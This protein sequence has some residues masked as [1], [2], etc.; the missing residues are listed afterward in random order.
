MGVGLL[1]GALAAGVGAGTTIAAGVITLGFSFT[2]ALTSLAVGALSSLL[3]PK[4]KSADF[5][6]LA[7]GFSSRANGITQNI[8]QAIT[9]RRSIYGDVRV[10][11]SLVFIESTE[12]DKY[13]H[14]VLVICDHEVE[15][16]GEVWFD[17]VSIPPDYIDGDGNV[18][19]GDF[20]NR[21]RIKKYLGTDA[22]TA[23]AD[24]VAETSAASTFRGR[25]VSYMYVRLEFDRDVYPTDIPTITAFVKGKK[26]FDTRDDVTRWTPNTSLF[27]YDF[28]REDTDA[29][30]PGLGVLAANI[31]ETQM[32]A[33]ANTCDEMVT[34][35]DLDDTI[36]EADDTT[37]I[38]TLTGVNGRLQ[39]Q[40]G[41]Q[42][43]AIGGSLPTGLAEAT[44]YYVIPYQRKDTVRIKLATSLA[45][46]IAGT[47]VSITADGSGTIRK[48]AEPRYHGGSVQETGRDPDEILDDL[49]SGMGGSAVHVGDAWHILAAAYS[50]P[51][52]SFDENN[53]LSPLKIRTGVGRRDRF[54]LVKGVYA[55]PLNDG[56]PTDYP[57]VTNA[58]YVTNDNGRT[59]PI[60][61]DLPAT[62][63]P[64]TAQR[65]AKIKLEKHRQELF[66][67][68]DFDLD[69]FQVQPGDTINLSNTRMGWT[70]KVF[71]VV[72]WEFT[73]KTVNGAPLFYVKLILQET[74]SAAYDWNN[75]EETAVDPAPNTSLPNPLQ[76]GVVLGFSLDSISSQTQDGDAIYNVVAS[77]LPP[78]DQFVISGGQFEVE[79]KEADQVTYKSDGRVDGTVT[80]VQL[81]ALNPDTLYDIR[82]FAFNSL[83][84]RSP[85]TEIN[86][87]TVGQTVSSEVQ[88]WEAENLTTEDWENDTLATKDWES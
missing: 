48:I 19:T 68:A 64:H 1:V 32:I 49:L 9:V 80:E 40:I 65:L 83:G 76:V 75:G 54:N 86:D 31:N 6:A 14:L 38:I 55:S 24:L 37:D 77:W 52:F 29:F 74:A 7:G 70:N 17:D 88:D 81:P 18:T 34:T 46:A 26:C 58:T 12:D 43:R 28:L 60:D 13:L 63:R 5:S 61:L 39:Y 36:E 66:V 20:E 21:A 8:R 27:A 51:E 11:G 33:A 30:V 45:N 2:A 3:T 57:P 25:G 15:E 71:E 35:T 73:S 79:Y 44:D 62:Q 42:V 10:G 84:V 23:D 69:A 16:I 22:Q 4:P 87:F 85:A 53:L 59:I 78:A 41:D 72:G 56:Q 47:A 82:I 50:T 67:E